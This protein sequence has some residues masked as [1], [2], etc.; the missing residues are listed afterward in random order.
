MSEESH[1]SI[2]SSERRASSES[3][4]VLLVDRARFEIVSPKKKR[5]GSNESG[6]SGSGSG[7]GGRRLER[8]FSR[9][10]T[11]RKLNFWEEI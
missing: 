9:D 4:E 6:S 3:Q 10:K 5:Q 1:T 2:R 11:P 8:L 7:G